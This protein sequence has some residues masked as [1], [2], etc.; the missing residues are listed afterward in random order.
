M[1]D[2][3]IIPPQTLPQTEELS[4]IP[5][6]ADPTLIPTPGQDVTNR[7]TKLHFALGKRSPG[8]TSLESTL[9]AGQEEEIR[10]DL[11]H[12]ERQNDAQKRITNITQA[13]QQGIDPRLAMADYMTQPQYNRNVILEEQ[14]AQKFLYDFLTNSRD[15]GS[16]AVTAL[17]EN[18]EQAADILQGEARILAK[19]QVAHSVYE[20]IKTQNKNMGWVSWGANVVGSML[21]S[22][23][24]AAMN[25]SSSVLESAVNIALPGSSL[26]AERQKFLAFRDVGQARIWLEGR[27][28]E[29]AKWNPLD[30]EA[31]AKH[32]VEFSYD[33]KF[34]QNIIGAL[35]TTG[36]ASL[37]L[38]A[39]R[40][41]L[42]GSTK[43][44][45]DGSVN[46]ENVTA[47]RGDLETAGEHRLVRQ[48][49]AKQELTSQD[50]IG[51][52][53]AIWD[54]LPSSHVGKITLNSGQMARDR[55]QKLGE[56][57]DIDFGKGMGAVAGSPRAQRIP[58]ENL[59][60]MAL[61]KRDLILQQFPSIQ[62]H[63]ID[64]RIIYNPTTNTHHIEVIIANRDGSLFKS[65]SQADNYLQNELK[66]DYRIAVTGDNPTVLAKYLN[67]ESAVAN[68][69][70]I[71]V[72]GDKIE[73]FK[74]IQG[75]V[76][77]KDGTE[78]KVSNRADGI[79][80]QEI[81][82]LKGV[83]IKVDTADIVAYKGPRKD[84]AWTPVVHTARDLTKAE[85]QQ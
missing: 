33:D 68:I 36:L 32:M 56:I 20:D 38:S 28:A 26:E 11:V 31:F 69:P 64:H 42:K 50:P 44:L 65:P 77:L 43:G 10:D 78:I 66:L 34:N 63:V 84:A 51:A 39:F 60:T 40:R 29:I 54:T 9:L 23:S 37:S 19:Q 13:A 72:R 46:P 3:S 41:S 12:I 22:V 71:N 15:P 62:D 57:I 76:R 80:S 17:N 30:A 48:R 55:A 75:S 24:A 27:V 1:A 81:Q 45:A 8:I 53:E 61:E 16:P 67:S 35:D 52:T 70:L 7:A 5:P 47:A 4:I 49:T 82:G 85:L 2:L 59:A 18:P 74:S 6:T 79:Y 14:F 73:G 21:P 25:P 83:G 58:E